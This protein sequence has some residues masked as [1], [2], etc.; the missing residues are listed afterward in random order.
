MFGIIKRAIGPLVI[1][2]AAA[3]TPAFAA[4]SP[5]GVWIDH[6]GRGAVE[7]TDCNGKL[8][9]RLV[10][11]Q[12]K[13][14]ENEGCNF[15]IIGDVRPVSGGKWDG[16]WIIDPDKDPDKKYDVEITPLDGNK[17]VKKTVPVDSFRPNPWGLYQV[18]GNV[19][20]W[21]EDVAH[22]NYYGAPTDGSAWLQG[23]DPS[24]RMARGGSW[25]ADPMLLSCATRYDCPSDRRSVSMGFRVARAVIR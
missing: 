6:T 3:S 10:W 25:D 15:Q 12:D 7:I 4:S 9:G 16:G 23:G 20:E 13:K 8:C 1:T 5:L 17:A 21:C 2:V 11:F 18:H 19:T 14:H 24:Q 22:F